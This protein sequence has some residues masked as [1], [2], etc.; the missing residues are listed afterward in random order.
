MASPLSRIVPTYLRRLVPAALLAAATMLVG[1][2]VGD[3]VTASAAPIKDENGYIS[4]S[5]KVIDDYRNNRITR[6]QYGALLQMCCITHGGAWTP[7]NATPA[8]G[9]CSFAADAP[10]WVPPGGM[11]GPDPTQTFEP[12]PPPA[13]RTP[14]NITQ[15][16]TPAP[17]G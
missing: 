16:F 15:T 6:E 3:P 9:G 14:G 1:S 2:A 17:V 4:C 11:P 13:A 10:G 8:G 5:N 12:A 7:S